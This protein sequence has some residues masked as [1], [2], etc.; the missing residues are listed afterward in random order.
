[1][2]YLRTAAGD[3]I[4]AAS[5]V[6]LSPQQDDDGDES[7]GWLAICEDGAEIALARYYSADRVEKELPHLIAPAPVT[8]MACQCGSAPGM[9]CGLA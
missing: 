5:I 6:R 2:R 3:F 1:M 8:D 9:E 4:N 7:T